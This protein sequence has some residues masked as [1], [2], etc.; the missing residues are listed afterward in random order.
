MKVLKIE[1]DSCIG[2]F[3]AGV[4]YEDYAMSYRNRC[5]HPEAK[6]VSI[7]NGEEIPNGCPLPNSPPTTSNSD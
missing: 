6:N 4:Y 5:E 2:C 1:I 3:Y 7:G